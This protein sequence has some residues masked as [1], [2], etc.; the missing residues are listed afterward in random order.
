MA[1]GYGTLMCCVQEPDNV[2]FM[3]EALERHFWHQHMALDTVVGVVSEYYAVHRPW[4]YKDV[5][6]EWVV[7][8]F[9]GSYMNR[10]KEFGLHPPRRLPDVAR[11]VND[12]HHSAALALAAIWPLNYWRIDP[13]DE[14]D[15]E[16]F[17]AAYPGWYAR[18]GGFW[19]MY[20]AMSDPAS[21]KIPLQLLPKLPPF[22]QVCHVPCVMPR[23]DAPE[24]RLFEHEGERYAVCSEGC[25][26]IFKLNPRIYTGCGNWW[27]PWH[28]MNLADVIAALGYVRPDGKTLMGQPHLN[29]SRMWTLDDIRR[30]DYIVE[31]PLRS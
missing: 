13:L 26:W 4:V 12:M 22:C 17:E 6:E 11:F 28:G 31:D 15:F 30:L 2:P 27:A 8:D 3:N 23:F 18:Y 29:A 5:W 1:N 14:R 20:R 9:I 7:D 25:E 19:E 10:L 16:W 24:T 21:G